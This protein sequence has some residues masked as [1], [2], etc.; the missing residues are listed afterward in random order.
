MAKKKNWTHLNLIQNLEAQDID[1]VIESLDQIIEWAKLNNSKLGYFPSLYRKVT[2]RIRKSILEGQFENGPLIEGL[3][4]KFANRYFIALHAYTHGEI[5]TEAWKMSFIS[6]ELW[7]PIVLQHLLL[8]MNAHINLD[9]GIAA[10]ETVDEGELDTIKNDFYK[11]N[12]ILIDMIG[13]VKMDLAKIWPVLRL[14]NLIAGKAGNWLAKNGMLA[15]RNFS[16][17]SAMAVNALKGVDREE[18]IDFI[19][20]TVVRVSENIL[21]PGYFT[22]IIIL[23]IRLTEFGSVR[24]I[25]KILE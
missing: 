10:V 11:I 3:D 19:D 13:E 5:C 25:I 21:L 12:E 20:Q 16:W 8:G 9:L 14:T 2:K 1:G 6:A 17:K 24:K 4:V 7:Q 22:V 18:K 15:S 23:M